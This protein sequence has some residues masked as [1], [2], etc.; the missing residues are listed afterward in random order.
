MLISRCA[1]PHQ[2]IP[3]HTRTPP[4]QSTL[5]PHLTPHHI[6]Q[7]KPR[8]PHHTTPHYITPH[9][10]TSHYATH[11]TTPHHTTPP[12]P[13][14]DPSRPYY[15]S[16]PSR[17]HSHFDAFTPLRCH[18][19]HVDA[20]TARRS[21]LLGWVSFLAPRGTSSTLSLTQKSSP[22]MYFP[23]VQLRSTP[24]THTHTHTY[25]IS[26]PLRQRMPHLFSFFPGN[27]SFNSFAIEIYIG[28]I[29][30]LAERFV[31]LK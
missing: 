19:H 1:T 29:P 30:D 27:I 18:P 24:H 23:K 14:H 6:T 28:S 9:T 2:I 25:I 17:P 16:Q 8:N 22:K 11:H 26:S 5:P 31:Y 10:A 12:R 15:Q 3:H 20:F 4:G 13:K 21:A 7:P